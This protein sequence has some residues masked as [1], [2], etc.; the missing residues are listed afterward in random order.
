MEPHRTAEQPHTNDN[1][2]RVLRT[3]HSFDQYLDTSRYLC[4]NGTGHARGSTAGPTGRGSPHAR[5]YERRRARRSQMRA[6]PSSP[7]SPRTPAFQ[8]LSHHRTTPPSP[9]PSAADTCTTISLS[10]SFARE[11]DE[12][13]DDDDHYTQ[14]DDIM[15]RDIL[16]AMQQ[17]EEKAFR[18]GKPNLDRLST[19]AC[20]S[21]SS[22]NRTPVR[23]RSPSHSPFRRLRPRTKAPV[24]ES[25]GDNAYRCLVRM[26]PKNYRHEFTKSQ[27]DLWTALG[28]SG[29]EESKQELGASG[30]YNAVVDDDDDLFSTASSSVLLPLHPHQRIMA[31]LPHEESSFEVDD[32]SGYTCFRDSLGKEASTRLRASASPAVAYRL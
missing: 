25:H 3:C 6:Q 1:S 20:P 30:S 8:R 21:A 5:L 16:D 26:S 24:D 28:G 18:G 27:A 22:P 31:P 17:Q 32:H 23:N 29:A 4:A 9:S 11:F 12:D 14:M 13:D 19:G 2:G 10:Q 15:E 7:L